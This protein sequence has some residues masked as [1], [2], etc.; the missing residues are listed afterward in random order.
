[1]KNYL[2]ED[3]QN[4][5]I[6]GNRELT[7]SMPFIDILFTRECSVTCNTGSNGFDFRLNHS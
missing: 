3:Y 1:M 7:A 6:E 5:T 2:F 4:N